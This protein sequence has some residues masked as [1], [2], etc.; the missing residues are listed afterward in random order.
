MPGSLTTRDWTGPMAVVRDFE[1]GPSRSSAALHDLNPRQQHCSFIKVVW[2]LSGKL[3]VN[4]DG[5]ARLGRSFLRSSA[6]RFDEP[7]L[8]PPFD[9]TVRGRV[10]WT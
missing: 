9:T 5:R 3:V 2:I 8:S 7:R 10:F 6:R 4:L 1:T